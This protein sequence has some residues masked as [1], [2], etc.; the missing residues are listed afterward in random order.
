MAKSV[1]PTFLI[2]GAAKAGTTSLYRY[3]RQHP[4]VYMPA[5]I[6]ET[7]FFSRASVTEA[8]GPGR[9]YGTQAVTSWS[10]Y[11]DL[12]ADANAQPARGEA[13]TAYLYFYDEAI[14][15]IRKYLGAGVRIVIILRD[16]VERAYSNYMHHV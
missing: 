7:F 5:S 1:H 15:E 16:P 3:L 13:C 2:V 14:P 6:K 11:A 8:S 10:D 4:D 12:F 9:R